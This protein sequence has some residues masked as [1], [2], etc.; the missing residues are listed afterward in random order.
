MTY[1]EHVMVFAM[2][3]MDK[4]HYNFAQIPMHNLNKF[5]NKLLRKDEKDL[6]KIMFIR[7]VVKE[8]LTSWEILSDH[9]IRYVVV[10]AKKE[11]N[12]L[13]GS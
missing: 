2:K 12:K 1:E 7:D 6:F 4:E 10:Q 11:I 3:I 13:Q 9:D 8:Y 5:H